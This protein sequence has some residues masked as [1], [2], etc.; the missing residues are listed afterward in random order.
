MKCFPWLLGSHSVKRSKFSTVG[1]D[2]DLPGETGLVYGFQWVS[3]D[4][5]TRYCCSL[6]LVFPNNASEGF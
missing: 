2:E 3:W 6:T 5:G 1:D 4:N